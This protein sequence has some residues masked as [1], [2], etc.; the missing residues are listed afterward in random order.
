QQIRDAAAELQDAVTLSTRQFSAARAR[1]NAAQQS[2]RSS[3]WRHRA[4]LE[5][6]KAAQSR[7][8]SAD[9]LFEF[10]AL[11]RQTAQIYLDRAVEAAF[12]MQ[13]AFNLEYNTRV[14]RIRLDY[15]DL[16]VLDGLYAA[17]FLLRDIDEFTLQSVS[18]IQ[19]K[20]QSSVRV[21]SLRRDFPFA[22]LELIQAGETQFETTLSDFHGDL[23][24]TYD[25]RIKRV[26]VLVQAN[27]GPDGVAGMLSCSGTSLVRQV[28]GS[29]LRKSH[30]TETLILP[31]AEVKTEIDA[32]VTGAD[33]QLEVFENVGV[34]TSWSLQLPP[35]WNAVDLK[36]F[37][38]VKVVVA[39]WFR[40]SDAL[41]QLDLHNLPATEEAEFLFDITRVGPNLRNW[42][43]LE[44][45][46]RTTI[47]M[48]DARI[49]PHHRR[50]VKLKRLAIIVVRPDAHVQPVTLRLRA[51]TSDVSGEFTS[52]A[53]GMV[54]IASE[55]APGDFAGIPLS[56]DYELELPP[57]QNPDL[58][59]GPGNDLTGVYIIQFAFEYEYSLAV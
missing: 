25:G 53:D 50:D 42:R 14:D 27:S 26:R 37:T 7:V 3:R 55:D 36:S 40:H 44:S 20:L 54:V 39:Y 5:N 1:R 6:L 46:A 49:P 57:A 28:D 31:R 22:L 30:S 11:A 33:G 19:N 38:D 23:P 16:T 43:D 15:G 35:Q 17:D 48:N 4:S 10:G 12:L 29:T 58:G 56:Q 9:L 13:Q 47:A 59:P 34:A 51:A 32:P 52:S 45:G 2:V 24:G 41:Q 8:V 18:G 21:L